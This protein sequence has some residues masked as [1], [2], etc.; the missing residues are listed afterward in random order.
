MVIHIRFQKIY[1][2]CIG[3][4]LILHFFLFFFFLFVC[5]FCLL[6][7]R[8]VSFSY[9]TFYTSIFFFLP[10]IVFSRK[11]FICG[12]ILHFFPSL[13]VVVAKEKL[14]LF[15]VRTSKKISKQIPFLFFSSSSSRYKYFS[16]F[17]CSS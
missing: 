7:L 16:F 3:I 12:E 9:K 11:I 17:F 15:V 14:K 13:T 10:P 2:I 6:P 5:F 1:F 4:I 8:F